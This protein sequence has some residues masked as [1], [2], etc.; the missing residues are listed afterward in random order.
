VG[1]L[2]SGRIAMR[3]VAEQSLPLPIHSLREAILSVERGRDDQQGLLRWRGSGRGISEVSYIVAEESQGRTRLVAR[4][5]YVYGL[6]AIKETFE[7][8]STR[9]H[10]GGHRWW[11][12]CPG[13]RRRAGVLYAPAGF[14]RCRVCHQITYE[15]SCQ[16]DR[17]ISD[18]LAAVEDYVLGRG[19][20]PLWQN[21]DLASEDAPETEQITAG[22]LR[23]QLKALYHMRRRLDRV[24]KRPTPH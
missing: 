8:T 20:D 9:Q 14:W 19:D 16:S 7:L 21:F 18:R 22:E 10:L 12:I 6:R 24:L 23:L 15:T 13:C 17:R 4:L 3:P 11:F 1:G 5:D 2:G